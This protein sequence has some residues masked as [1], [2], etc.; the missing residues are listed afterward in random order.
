M[1]AARDSPYLPLGTPLRIH[2]YGVV[3]TMSEKRKPTYDLGSFQAWAKS[4]A[5][6]AAGS[7]VMTAA[8]MG[9]GSAEMIA[10]IQK[11]ER[12][13]FDKSVTSFRDHREWQDVY[14]VPSEVGTIY[15][16]FRSDVVTEFLLL[17]F[18]EKDNG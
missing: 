14:H 13:H 3:S 11:I 16:K 5:F 2:H 4:S 12:K 7:A 17:S 18:K 8:G 9:F 15:V 10:V 1:L 6:R